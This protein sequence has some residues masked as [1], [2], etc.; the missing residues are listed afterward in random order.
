MA[1]IDAKR[2]WTP[3]MDEF[4]RQLFANPT[5]DCG[6]TG[7]IAAA[8][9][10]R[11]GRL[12]SRNSVIGRRHRLGLVL[13]PRPGGKPRKGGWSGYYRPA[14]PRKDP[15]A[16]PRAARPAPAASPSAAPSALSR[17]GVAADAPPPART[18]AEGLFGAGQD[19]VGCRWVFGDPIGLGPAAP[20]RY[21]QEDQ[22]E[23][24]VYCLR[25]RARTIASAAGAAGAAGAG[26]RKGGP[27]P[28]DA[29]V[30]AF[31]RERIELKTAALAAAVAA[32]F[33]LALDGPRIGWLRRR[34]RNGGGAQR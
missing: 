12:I 18:R 11:F 15:K 29:A 24:S 8:I 27:A 2:F 10:A 17:P 22:A 14:A 31:V 26:A 25:H 33:G 5:R 32:A 9:S 30:L 4:L 3:E 16:A 7:Q 6:T 34:A 13:P 23:R 19:P 21:C 28:R 20:W 1:R